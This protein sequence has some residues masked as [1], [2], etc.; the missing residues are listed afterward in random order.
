MHNNVSLPVALCDCG[1]SLT[2]R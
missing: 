2:L 1:T